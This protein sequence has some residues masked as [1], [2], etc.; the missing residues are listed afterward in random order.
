M[1]ALSRRRLDHSI[2]ANTW[3]R[4]NQPQLASRAYLTKL[5]AD[6]GS[7]VTSEIMKSARKDI[8][9]TEVCSKLNSYCVSSVVGQ[10]S[11]S[12]LHLFNG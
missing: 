5:K 3:L 9:P 4:I 12:Q 7:T 2:S 1:A 6:R 11:T 10:S 8:G